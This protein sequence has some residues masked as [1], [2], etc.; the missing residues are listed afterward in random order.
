[1]NKTNKRNTGLTR[2]KF[3]AT[4]AAATAF[5]IVPR[6]VVAG[7][8]ETAPSERVA[9]G[10]IGAGE[11][12]KYALLN[13][14]LPSKKAQVTAICDTAKWR[15][16]EA[17]KMVDEY[18]DAVGCDGHADFRELLEDKSVDAVFVGTPDHWHTPASVYAARAGKDV[19][20]EKPV[21][22]FVSE[23]RVLCDTMQQ[24]GRIFQ[25]GTQGRS[26]P[27]V[28]KACE[29]VRNGKIGALESI[30]I[31]LPNDKGVEDEHRE[32]GMPPV[33][34]IPEGF[35]YDMW[36]GQTPERPYRGRCFWQFRW[37]SAYGG[38]Y[39][40]DWGTHLLDVA[41]WMIDADGSGPV[42]I[43]G[44]GK[45]LSGGL[46]DVHTT[47]DI[48]YT[49]A[50]GVRVR[51]KEGN[52]GMRVNGS[53][54]WF[55]LNWHGPQIADGSQ[56]FN[57]VEIKPDEIHVYKSDNHVEDFLECVRDHKQPISPAE[58]GHRSATMCHLGIIAMD[59]GKALDWD[60]ATEQFSNSD[61]ANQLLSREPRAPW[62]L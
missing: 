8:Q 13:G 34:P 1:M 5:T 55:Y 52:G 61:D 26:M 43:E 27:C 44:E 39:I 53:E 49:Y 46:Y 32:Q 12:G 3:L 25:S 24:H 38:G 14:F 2:R 30:E 7:A 10:V 60:P 47:Y 40:T 41:Q 62:L 18:Y 29:L 23:G 19:Y 16:T 31:D 33:Q 51:L 9:V 4:T 11:R 20:S 22:L 58:V 57:K 42:R 37:Q 59:V 45:R 28:R 35:D 21:T 36:Q 17:R 50:N 48:E 56:D 6:H 54:G 15:V